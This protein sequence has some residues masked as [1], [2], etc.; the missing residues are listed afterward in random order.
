MRTMGLFNLAYGTLGVLSSDF[1]Q[2]LD[3]AAVSLWVMVIGA[4][5]FLGTRR[6]HRAAR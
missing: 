1:L 6:G 4:F 2:R 3:G 5:A